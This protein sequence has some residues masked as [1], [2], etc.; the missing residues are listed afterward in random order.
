[1]DDPKADCEALLNWL[2][3]LAEELLEE[4]AQFFP[5]GGAMTADGAMVSVTGHDEGEEPAPADLVGLIKAAF[6]EGAARGAFKATALVYDAR[7]ALSDTEDAS[8]AIAA[9][10][11]HRGRY[12]VTVLFPYRIDSGTLVIDEPDAELGGYDIFPQA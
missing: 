4:S 12:S 3:P 5:F 10:L 11:N 2:F 9:E 7:V 8:Q 6:I 1:M